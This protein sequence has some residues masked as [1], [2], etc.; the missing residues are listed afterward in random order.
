MDSLT[1]VPVHNLQILLP[2]DPVILV[3]LHHHVLHVETLVVSRS[4]IVDC[5]Y[6]LSK[7]PED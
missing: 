6:I 3:R 7:M 2:Q 4:L 1:Y 5:I